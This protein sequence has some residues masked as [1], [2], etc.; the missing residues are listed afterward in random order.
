[1]NKSTANSCED[2]IGRSFWGPIRQKEMRNGNSGFDM[3]LP[4]VLGRPNQKQQATR[5]KISN[6][7]ET[8]LF[9]WIANSIDKPGLKYGMN[10]P[11]TPVQTRKAIAAQGDVNGETET[12]HLSRQHSS[13]R[14]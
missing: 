2:L 1:M 8:T 6:H 13:T 7:H 14:Q 12:L 3:G 9:H 11:K 5:A 10:N 4:K